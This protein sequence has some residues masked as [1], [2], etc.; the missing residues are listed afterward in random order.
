MPRHSQA[1]F[2]SAIDEGDAK[3]IWQS[4]DPKHRSIVLP[5]GYPAGRATAVREGLIDTAVSA[6]QRAEQEMAIRQQ[7]SDRQDAALAARI[8]AQQY[9]QD[10]DEQTHNQVTAF[11]QGLP[12]I[13]KQYKVGTPDYA[14]AFGEYLSNFPLAASTKDIQDLAKTHAVVH[15]SAADLRDKLAAFKQATGKD[16][17]GIEMTATG[18]SNLRTNESN[19]QADL[20][21]KLFTQTGLTPDQ[22]AGIDM[23]KAARGTLADPALLKN[24]K[25]APPASGVGVFTNAYPEAATGDQIKFDT[26]GMGSVT[27]PHEDFMRYARAFAPDI[28]RQQTQPATSAPTAGDIKSG[29]RFKG[30]DPANKNNWEKVQ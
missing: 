20:S 26:G 21:K 19:I 5:P 2:Q 18:G 17:T 10:K 27:I 12:Q 28:A 15:D 3:V 29:Y 4:Q 25:V 1:A 14:E 22:F 6:R 16:A 7:A 23:S 8:A 9:K 13:E 11:Y 24:N 30:G